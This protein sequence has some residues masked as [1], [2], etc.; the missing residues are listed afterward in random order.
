MTTTDRLNL[1]ELRGLLALADKDAD[2]EW[3]VARGRQDP[4]TGEPLPPDHDQDRDAIRVQDQNQRTIAVTGASHTMAPHRAAL[5]AAG[6]NHLPALLDALEKVRRLASQH[7]DDCCSKGCTGEGICLI[8]TP[9]GPDGKCDESC[10]CS[11]AVYRL[12]VGLPLSKVPP[13]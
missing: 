9:L 4:D 2:D 7:D 3:V 1:D 8:A 10:N 6:I 11:V 13:T 5:I 12:A